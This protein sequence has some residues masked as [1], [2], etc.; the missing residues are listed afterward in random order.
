MAGQLGCNAGLVEGKV[1]SNNIVHFGEEERSFDGR[2][3]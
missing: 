2:R 1:S 3:L